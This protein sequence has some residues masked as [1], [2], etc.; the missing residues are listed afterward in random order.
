LTAS[1]YRAQVKN[2][3]DCLKDCGL[4][5]SDLLEAISTQYFL[6]INLGRSFTS[7]FKI[8]IV[9]VFEHKERM[10]EI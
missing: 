2:L 7:S 10:S 1:S 3:N 6:E 5:F 4:S 8:Q 9:E